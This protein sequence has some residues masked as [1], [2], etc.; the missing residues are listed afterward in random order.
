[1]LQNFNTDLSHVFE[2]R[3]FNAADLAQIVITNHLEKELLRYAFDT[4]QVVANRAMWVV[5]HCAAIDAKRIKP[6]Y[7]KLINHLKN[8]HI[9]NGVIRSILGIFQTQS[10]PKKHEIF[11][12]DKCYEYIKNPS[13]AI[14]VRAFAMTV[15][16]NISKSY[17]DLLKE[18][19][20]VLIHLNI[21]EESAGIKSRVKH[22][23]NAINKQLVK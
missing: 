16:F 21:T 5:N 10:V 23:L 14:A 8:K 22:T 13:E 3:K 15:A 7:S 6:F 11:M 20:I 18:L 2:N 12:L 19:S 9:H 4:N 17:N 1:M